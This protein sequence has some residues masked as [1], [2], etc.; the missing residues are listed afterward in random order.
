MHDS[1]VTAWRLPPLSRSVPEAR[2]DVATTLEEWGLASLVET[3]VLLVSE[4]V[5][6]AVLHA[7]TD[8]TLTVARVG[9]GVR[10]EVSDGSSLPPAMRWHSATATTGRG[11]RMLDLLADSWSA[12]STATGK[13][14]WF[15]VTGER[16]P[17]ASAAVSAEGGA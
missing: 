8:L 9:T 14:V 7:R 2:R 13:T 6:N 4:V 17:W 11:L 5:T 10:I 15:T 12:E 3:A 16:D 1:P